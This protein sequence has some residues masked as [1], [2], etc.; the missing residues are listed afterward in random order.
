[1]PAELLAE[2]DQPRRGIDLAAQ[3]AMPGAGRVRVMEVVPGLAKGQDGQPVHVPRLVPDLELCLTEEVAER[4]D[5]PA[6]ALQERDPDKSGPEERAKSA[7]PGPGPESADKCR[8][9][10]RERDQGR[11]EGRNPGDLL[12]G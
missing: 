12:V 6:H 2:P 8:R 4:V 3:S 1:H 5:A 10:Q 9:K 7:L 11:E